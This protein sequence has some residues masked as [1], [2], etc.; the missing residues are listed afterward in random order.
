MQVEIGECFE[1]V[2]DALTSA[3]VAL[4]GYKKVGPA[5]R[6]ELP[7][8]QAGNWLR[9]CLNPARREKLSPEQFLLVL[10]MA[11]RQQYHA[12]MDFVAFDT[13][14][15]ARPVDPSSQEAELQTRFADA[16]DKLTAIQAQLQRVQAREAARAH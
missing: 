11:Q 4:G 2:N 14:Y 12:A 8:E 7:I 15:K 13:G 6:P 16:V 1:C 10:R 5:M 9:D 3:V